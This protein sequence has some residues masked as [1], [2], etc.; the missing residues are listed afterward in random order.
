MCGV[1]EDRYFYCTNQLTPTPDEG[2]IALVSFSE[3][4]EQIQ[5]AESPHTLCSHRRST[6]SSQCPLPTLRT[7]IS[8]STFP[9]IF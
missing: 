3:F 6:C 2:S 7:I 5:Y 1:V 8:S 9:M 4:V